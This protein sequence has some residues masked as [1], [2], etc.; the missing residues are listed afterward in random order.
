M[1][2]NVS[3]WEVDFHIPADKVEDALAAVTADEA[4]QRPCWNRAHN[5]LGDVVTAHD[6]QRTKPFDSL[7]EAVEELTGFHDCQEDDTDGF[8][9]GWHLPDKWFSATEDLLYVLGRYAAEGSFVRLLGE[10]SELFGY[11]VVDGKLHNEDATVTWT[12]S[13]SRAGAE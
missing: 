11:R 10:D 6:C 4:L 13:T 8:R 7:T 12:V 2:Y 3:T 5:A 1:G 9:L